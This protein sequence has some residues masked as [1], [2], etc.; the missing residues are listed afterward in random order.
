MKPTEAEEAARD[1]IIKQIQALIKSILPSYSTEVFGSQRTGLSLATSDIDIRLFEEGAEP[2]VNT[3]PDKAPRGKVRRK[4]DKDLQKLRQHLLIHQDYALVHKRPARYPLLS[5]QHKE[6]GFDI[7]VVCNNDTSHTR[8]AILGFL[9]ED[10][11]LHALFAVVKVIFDIR[12][13]TD[14]YRGG[15]GSYTL[16]IMTVAAIKYRAFPQM[17]SSLGHKFKRFLGFYAK[18]DQ[19]KSALSV[20]TCRMEPSW[21]KLPLVDA[22]A[23]EQKYL[24]RNDQVGR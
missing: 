24:V 3:R 11:D 22:Q 23:L 14:V 17:E 13:L 18:F 2:V 4:L 16:F 1:R 9:K 21:S 10:P 8:E 15:A 19:Y 12:G 7:Q 5:L 6:S 20:C